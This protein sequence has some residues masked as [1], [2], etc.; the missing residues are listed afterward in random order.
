L[1]AQQDDAIGFFGGATWAP[2][3]DNEKSR[4]FV[5]AFEAKFDRVPGTYA[6]QAYDAA[7]LIDSALKKVDGNLED[8]DALRDALR[9]ADFQSLRGDFEFGNNHY[10]IQDFYL[11]E[12]AKRDDG[13]YQTEISQKIF[14]DYQDTYASEC[15]MDWK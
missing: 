7:Q 5:A 1:P 12:V 15:P 11:V 9:E 13:K 14:D 10:P 2:D 8:Q 6:M 3:M 4:A